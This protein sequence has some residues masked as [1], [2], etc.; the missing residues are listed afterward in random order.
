MLTVTKFVPVSTFRVVTTCS[1]ISMHPKGSSLWLVLSV[2]A[3]L[4]YLIC[5]F[6]SV[7]GC[8][9]VCLC[10]CVCVCARSRCYVFPQVEVRLGQVQW[11]GPLHRPIWYQ[12]RDSL[13]GHQSCSFWGAGCRWQRAVWPSE[14]HCGRP[15]I[16]HRGGEDKS[17]SPLS[18]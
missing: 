14:G 4:C 3:A 12:C 11:G 5:F 6:L 7:Y 13:P 9:S 17:G 18:L 10:L 16:L 15:Q 8:V 2:E 1:S